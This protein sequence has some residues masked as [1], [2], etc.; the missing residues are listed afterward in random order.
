MGYRRGKRP[1]RRSVGLQFLPNPAQVPVIHALTARSIVD[2]RPSR[3]KGDE[4]AEFTD[5]AM[6]CPKYAAQ[7]KHLACVP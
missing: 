5:A 4:I 7:H 2:P 1:S 6:T 3:R